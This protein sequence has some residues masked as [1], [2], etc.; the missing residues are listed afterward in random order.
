MSKK[1][2][3]LIFGGTGLIGSSI[4]SKFTENNWRVISISRKKKD[5]KNHICWDVINDSNIDKLLL[6]IKKKGPF[7]SVCW[8]QGENFN[9]N[10]YNFDQEKHLEIYKTNVFYILKSLNLLLKLQALNKGARLCILGSIWQH[11]SRQDKLS[12]GISKSALHGLVLS[13]A[14]DMAK[15]GFLVNA[16][17]PGVIDT[18]MT[19]NNLTKEQI[20]NVKKSTNFM[21]LTELRD[22]VN[23]VY[24]LSSNENTGVTGVFIKVDLGYS[25]VR[26]I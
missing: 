9:D 14:N 12:Y 5:S 22:V 26:I 17:L 15:D 10:V 3:L 20:K 16:V 18:P 23:T 4:V 8:A 25:S 13:L 6:E 19:H 21:K 24:F 1:K 2:S 11:I 7:D